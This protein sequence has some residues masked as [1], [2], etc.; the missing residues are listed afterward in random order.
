MTRHELK[1]LLE[2]VRSGALTPESAQDRFLQYLRQAPF[3]DL[4]F[5]RVDHHR[6][7]QQGFPEV[8]FGPGKPPEQIAS[9]ADRIVSAG[10]T[11]L[12]TRTDN[13]AYAAVAERIRDA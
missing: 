11:L 7:A 4:G 13:D 2:Q 12:I 8:V 9:I 6:S 3:E 10:H 1:T 5:A